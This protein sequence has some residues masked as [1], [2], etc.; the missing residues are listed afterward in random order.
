MTA[1]KALPPRL[2]DTKAEKARRAVAEGVARRGA[3]GP[4]RATF[5][6]RGQP[7]G[8]GRTAVSPIGG[9]EPSV[10]VTPRR[11]P[12]AVVEPVAEDSGDSAGAPAQVD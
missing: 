2:H 3:N 6:G 5:S 4:P 10:P 9:G 7:R 12:K 11:R 1:D 8:P